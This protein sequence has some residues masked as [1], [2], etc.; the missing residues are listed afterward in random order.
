MQWAK[1]KGCKKIVA[2][3]TSSRKAEE[4]KKLGATN[5][6][7]LD[8]GIPDDL[9]KSVDF[10]IICGSGKS[11]NWEQLFGLIKTRGKLVLLD[12][13]E[14]PIPLAPATL[15]Y[16]HISIV[17]TFVGSHEDLEEML[18]F[19]S[20]KGVRPWVEPVGNSLD[21]VNRGIEKMANGNAHYRIVISGE[22]RE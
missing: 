1:A 10:L 6:I 5:F 12:L 21:E 7:A 8:Q 9:Q 17:A 13:P 4:A 2:V 15:I 20:E 3:S 16:R 19:A 18:A 22:G 11:T 14:Q